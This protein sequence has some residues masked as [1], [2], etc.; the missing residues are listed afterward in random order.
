MKKNEL[1]E[2]LLTILSGYVDTDLIADHEDDPVM[3]DSMEFLEIIAVVESELGIGISDGEI[4]AM[5]S[6]NTML[7]IVFEK[8]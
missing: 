6:F 2:K 8:I 4:M 5:E 1:K 7:D 3:I